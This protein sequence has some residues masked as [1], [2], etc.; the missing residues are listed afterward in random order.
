[1]PLSFIAKVSILLCQNLSIYLCKKKSIQ[2]YSLQSEPATPICGVHLDGNLPV[3][4]DL[5]DIS[6]SLQITT[7]GFLV[8]AILDGKL[9]QS[10]LTFNIIG[11]YLGFVASNATVKT[12]ATVLAFIP[13]DAPSQT[14]VDHIF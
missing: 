10:L 2:S 5:L 1:M 13:L 9:M 11:Y 4:G 7:D 6:H 14:I 8:Y 3:P 12:T